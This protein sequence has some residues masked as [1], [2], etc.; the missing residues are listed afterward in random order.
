MSLKG[1]YVRD[2]WAELT[3]QM[4]KERRD[5]L[6]TVAGIV[7]SSMFTSWAIKYVSTSFGLT[8]L[9]TDASCYGLYYAAAI[10]Y[11]LRRKGEAKWIALGAYAWILLNAALSPHLTWL[12]PYLAPLTMTLTWVALGWVAHRYPRQ[13]KAV[14]LDFSHLGRNVLWGLLTAGAMT[15]HMFFTR[16]FGGII[17]LYPGG[18][19]DLA[20]QKFF[21]ELGLYSISQELFF[22]GLI[23]GYLDN[24]R[25]SG[26]WKTA[27]LASCLN[28]LL[29]RKSWIATP[30]MVLDIW[31]YPFMMAMI[32]AALYRW[33]KSIV[34]GLISS[35]AFKAMT[36]F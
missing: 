4:E 12:S 17:Y 35:V 33:T 22:R 21:L 30:A 1:L 31:F 16:A 20:V 3:R 6:W 14:G 5:L 18:R 9:F 25:G 10:W 28:L 11:A 15:G 24:V 19:L 29:L 36:T 2:N 26:F 34:P 27:L 13:A 32:N 7:V 8:P 23:F